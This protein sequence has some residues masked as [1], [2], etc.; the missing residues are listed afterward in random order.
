[1]NGKNSLIL[2]GGVAL[3]ALAGIIVAGLWMTSPSRTVDQFLQAIETEG[4][5]SA[6][7]FVAE[8]TTAD[9]LDTIDFFIEDWTAADT[10][11]IKQGKEESWRSR[12]IMEEVDGEMVPVINEHGNEALEKVPVPEYWAHHYHLYLTVITEDYEDPV[13]IKLKRK[14]D[15]TWGFFSQ[16]FRTWEI[17]RIEFQPIDE[18]EDYEFDS[19]SEDDFFY[20]DETGAEN[21][22]VI[23]LETDE[24]GN[25]ILPE[26]AAGAEIEVVD[27]EGKAVKQ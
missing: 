13:I 25:L 4:N 21:E 9:R 19:M 5:K 2:G 16:I 23:E 26:D 11:E 24:E 18:L 10:L 7:Q 1:M 14:T 20:T 15:D 27:D 17:T 6:K 22:N 8:D 12:V 3:L